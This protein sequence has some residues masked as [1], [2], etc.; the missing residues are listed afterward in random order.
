MRY[1]LRWIGIFWYRILLSGMSFVPIELVLLS[2]DGSLELF[3]ALAIHP[4]HSAPQNLLSARANLLDSAIVVTLYRTCL[5]LPQNRIA[6]ILAW[7]I[8]MKPVAARTVSLFIDSYRIP[9][10]HPR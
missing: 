10:Q 7:A 9:Q 6:M 1:R 8:Q 5:Y 2:Q 3:A 4:Y